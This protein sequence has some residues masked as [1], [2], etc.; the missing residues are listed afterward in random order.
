MATGKV[1]LL[2]GDDMAKVA[3]ALE[4]LAGATPGTNTGDATALP[5]HDDGTRVLTAIQAINTNKLAT[6]QRAGWVKPDGETV[7]IDSDGTIHAVG[8]GSSA[9]VGDVTGATATASFTTIQLTWTDPNDAIIEG[10]TI[11]KWDGTKVVRKAGSAPTDVTDGTLVL[12]SKTRNAYA[13]TPF[14]DTGL[15]YGTTYY[16]RFFPYTGNNVTEGSSVNATPTRIS[17][18]VPAQSGSITYDGTQKTASWDSAYDATKMTVSGNTGTNAGNYTATFTLEDGYQWNDG[19][20][21]PT[22]TRDVT[23]TIDKAAGS[24]TLSSNSVTLDPDHETVNVTVS[25]LT[26]AATFSSNATSV[27]TVSPASMDVSGGTLTIS[28]VNETSGDATITVSVAASSNYL[29][30]TATITVTAEFLV[31]PAWATGT[32]AEIKAAVAAADAGTV[33][34]TEYWEVGQE[35]SMS[36]A[37]MSATGVG[38]SHVAQTV[39]MVLVAKDTKAQNNTNPC[40]NYPYVTAKSGRTY[41]S[42]IMQQK[43]GL[44]NGTT[45]EY[46]YMNSSHTNSGSW[47]GCA[48]RTWCNSVYR[49]AVP[50]DMRDAVKQVKVTTAQTYNGSTNKQSNDYFFLT[51][52]KEVFG[53]KTYCNDTEAAALCQWPYYATASNRIKNCGDSGSASYWWERSPHYSDSRSFCFVH[54]NGGATNHTAGNNLLIAPAGCI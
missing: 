47:D 43:N 38:E 36:L 31:I 34:L 23:W 18:P 39:T 27:A 12:N 17:I 7:T 20:A 26:G 21:N 3:Y 9:Y 4:T 5:A 41:P 29:A 13:S 51:A 25:G 44:A 14:E 11:A 1:G 10:V 45:G 42:F 46:G 35:R 22:G 52:E 40:Y 53:S 16:Y 37:A 2:N 28:S 15:T 32:D 6:E 24:V 49:P 8:G 50:S 48:R 54:Y 30:T 33:D 19:G